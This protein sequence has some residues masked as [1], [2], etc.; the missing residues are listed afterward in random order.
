MVNPILAIVIPLA[1]AFLMPF[2]RALSRKSVKWVFLAVIAFNFYVAIMTFLRVLSGPILVITAGIKPPFAINLLIGPLGGL[3]FLLFEGVAF[4]YAIFLL[5]A[6]IKEPVH[7]FFVL[8]LLNVAGATGMILTGDLFNLFV[9]LEITGISAYGLVGFKRDRK[10]LEGGVKYLILGSVGSTLFLL[11]VALLYS[12][13]GTLNMADIAARMWMLKKPTLYAA[14]IM[15]LVGLGVEA[16]LFPMNAWVPDAYE[17]AHDT[18]TAMLSTVLSKAGLYAL[19]RVVFTVLGPRRAFLDLLLWVGLITLLL[20]ELSA[21]RQK[22]VMRMIAY[23]SVGQMGLVIFAF[24]MGSLFALQAA[25]FQ[26]VNHVLSKGV[27]FLSLAIMGKKR[28]G[29]ELENLR[30]IG[31]ELPVT[32]LLFSIGALSLLGLPFLSGFWS[33]IS[34]LLST[35]DLRLWV[36]LGLVLLASIIESYYYLRTIGIFYSGTDFRFGET[37][38]LRLLPVLVLVFAILYLGFR[39]GVLTPYLKG[40]AKELVDRSSYIGW[41]IGGLRP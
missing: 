7:R 24:G 8:F 22:N 29:L 10:G 28:E 19:I 30:G 17:G 39:P 12:Q 27:L 13:L 2:F 14:F 40:A 6:E 41:V 31:R 33:K 37:A 5:K 34:L 16:E 32:G 11:G 36:P 38:F 25:L 3:L 9:F 15:F 21:L 26:A 35:A 20:A 23:S 1:F 4:L 18:V